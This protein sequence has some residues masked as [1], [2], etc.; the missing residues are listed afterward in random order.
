MGNTSFLPI[1]P[2]VILLIGAVLV[3]LLGIRQRAA[4][5]GFYLSAAPLGSVGRRRTLEIGAL[6]AHRLGLRFQC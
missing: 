2:E 3:L 4:R 6:D 1:A 5:V